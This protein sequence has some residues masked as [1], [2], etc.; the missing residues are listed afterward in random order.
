MNRIIAKIATIGAVCIILSPAVAR[1]T[2]RNV[3]EAIEHASAMTDTDPE[4]AI[5]LTDS[6]RR[7]CKT[8]D[9]QQA[10]LLIVEGNA[11]FTQ[12]ETSKGISRLRKALA[13]SRRAGDHN[14]EA[15]SLGDLGVMLRVAQKPDSALACYTEAL[16]IMHRHGADPDDEA[17]IL[18]STA[19][20]YTNTGRISDA[21]PFARKAVVYAEKADNIEVMMYVGS[22][23]GIILYKAGLKEEG[24]DI[25]KRIVAMAESKGSPRYALKTY[26]SIIDMYHHD[27]QKDSV[28]KYLKK[29][30]ILLSKVP[31]GS[32]ES[33]GFLEESYVVLADMGRHRESLDI[34]KRILAMKDAGTYMPLERLW[35]RVARNYRALGETESMAD[36]Y[37]RSIEL[38]DSLRNSD[39][40]RQLSE[41]NV[42]YETLQK[43][44]TI[45]RLESQRDR[46]R[47]WLTIWIAL[48][49]LILITATA[50]L[51]LRRRRE[52][53]EKIRANLK[54]VEEERARLA[55]ELHDGVCNDLYGVSLLM[56][57]RNADIGEITDNVRR[58][59]EEV[60]YISHELMPPQFGETDLDE[61]LHVYAVRSKGFFKYT[62][63][64]DLTLTK[65]TSYEL[66]RIIQ[67]LCAN[68]MTHSGAHSAEIRAIYETSGTTIKIQYKSS[69]ITSGGSRKSGGIGL[70]TVKRRAGLIHARIDTQEGDEGTIVTIK[71]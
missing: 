13:A 68:I 2:M 18:I 10:A 34:Q 52:A 71:I 54:G 41:F 50:F 37:E 28:T 60:R 21:V 61:L 59:R 42:K 36:A 57:T 47:L 6:I 35:L 1:G 15:Q 45:S 11:W 49:V 31:E 19:I 33:I 12:G 58:I 8:N 70:T 38:S 62:S 39:I 67:E 30:N 40:D 9:A 25:E 24:I 53:I 14:L 3:D 22:Q 69:G 5:S 27:G 7:H 55:R 66:Y 17:H 48:A 63:Q 32:V 46:D 16:D 26:A 64:G 56:Q 44:L 20:L 65:E 43:D 23:A 29:G 4:K 51:I